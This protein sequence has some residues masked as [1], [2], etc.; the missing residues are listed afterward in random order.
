ML[1]DRTIVELDLDDVK[2]DRRICQ[3]GAFSGS[4]PI[5][6]PTIAEQVAKV[7]GRYDDDLSAGPGRTVVH[8]WRGPEIWG[9]YLIWSAEPKSDDRGRVT[10]DISG[11]SLE[12]YLYHREIREDL[13]FRRADQLDIARGLVAHMELDR[14]IGLRLGGEDFSAVTRNRRYRSSEAATYGERLEEL[15]SVIDGPEWMIRTYPEGGRRVRE[16]TVAQRMGQDVTDH[17][18]AQP[19]DVLSWSYPADAGDVAT[20]WRARGDT[21]NDDLSEDSE[22]SLSRQWEDPRYRE[23]GWPLLERT[24]DYQSVTDTDV[25]DDYARWWARRSS[26]AVRFPQVTVR[27]G[28]STSFT[29]NNLGDRARLTLVNDWFPLTGGRPTFSKSWRVIGVEV[30]PVSRSNGQEQAS[31]I[32]EEPTEGSVEEYESGRGHPKDIAGKEVA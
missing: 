5:T 28:E 19:G 8:V 32:F 6:N 1:S 20:S 29:P 10:V 3:P 11:A 15:S 9:S 23:A 30:T 21:P 2:F 14:P 4:I 22:P 26:G 31:L 25:L 16:F 13:E 24:V 17:I 18:W 12:S 7:V 27:L